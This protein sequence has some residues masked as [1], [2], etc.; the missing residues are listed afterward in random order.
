MR[1]SVN[2]A[3][4][5]KSFSRVYIE[6]AAL[7]HDK[8]A[9]ILSNLLDVTP[10]TVKDYKHVFNRPGQNAA[11]Q[12]QAPALILAVKKP[13]YLYAGAPVCQSFGEA[14]FTYTSCAMNCPYDC[15]YCYLQGMYPSGDVV[16]YVNTEDI[17]AE[18]RKVLKEHPLYLCISFDTDLTAL[19]PV[20]G[21]LKDWAELAAQE[22]DLTLEVRT[23]CASCDSVA[24]LPVLRNM[25]F[26]YTLSPD[27]VIR[28]FEHR[29]PPLARRLAAVKQ[30]IHDGRQVRLCFDPML[31]IPDFAEVY[32]TFFDRVFSEINAEAIRD[33]SVGTFRIGADY[34]KRMRKVRPSEISYYPYTL[35]DGVYQ[36]SPAENTTMLR[37]AREKLL[38]YLPSDKLFFWEELT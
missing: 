21:Y 32:G 20:A 29:T 24:A 5:R 33:A 8:T 7:S 37:L 4:L 15:E 16:L 13:P 11:L 23:K 22:P 9:W 17:F 3:A 34:L 10:V 35:S 36:Y 30:A 12:K 26:A 31:H 27:A 19:E 1:H 14:H 28:A 38:T 6:E 18:V 25:I 2:T